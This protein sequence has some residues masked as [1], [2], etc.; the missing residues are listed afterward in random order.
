[1]SEDL[2]LAASTRPAAVTVQLSLLG[3]WQYSTRFALS[4]S[5]SG[6]VHAGGGRQAFK[7][8][9]VGRGCRGLALN[10]VSTYYMTSLFSGRQFR[11]WVKRA[12]LSWG[13]TVWAV[14][15]RCPKLV[16]GSGEIPSGTCHHVGSRGTEIHAL[17]GHLV[18]VIT[19]DPSEVQPYIEHKHKQS[20]PL[21]HYP[22]P[23]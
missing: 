12:S 23:I 9:R 19:D 8:C 1:M 20:P 10:E 7:R 11:V 3:V 2:E 5:L 22:H 14:A 4:L 6:E 17:T 13:K 15:C 21:Q 16:S 18:R